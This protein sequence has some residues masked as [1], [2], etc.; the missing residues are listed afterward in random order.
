MTYDTIIHITKFLQINVKADEIFEK[1]DM[2]Y[3]DFYSKLFHEFRNS[4]AHSCGNIHYDLLRKNTVDSQCF[5]AKILFDYIENHIL[6]N[7]DALEKLS[8]NKELLSRVSDNMTTCLTKSDG[9]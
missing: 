7:T 6:D 2:S 4:S 1:S 8:F 9:Q 5:A 3:L